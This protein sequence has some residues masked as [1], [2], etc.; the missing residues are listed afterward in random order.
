[1]YNLRFDDCLLSLVFCVMW[2]VCRSG[3]WLIGCYC[4]SSLSVAQPVSVLAVCVDDRPLVES[5][6]V[7]SLVSL[8]VGNLSVELAQS[9]QLIVFCDIR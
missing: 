8:C 4:P 2:G 5:F 7:D 3:C 6:L 9:R 1:M